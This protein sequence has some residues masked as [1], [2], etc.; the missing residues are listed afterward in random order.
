[1]TDDKLLVR[2]ARFAA[3]CAWAADSHQ[4]TAKMA[5][6]SEREVRQILR[7]CAHRERRSLS[8]LAR[9]S[10]IAL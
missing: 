2:R 9:R 3:G 8:S 5:E 1:M 6:E 7:D 4:I 10:A